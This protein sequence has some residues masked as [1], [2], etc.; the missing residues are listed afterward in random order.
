[1]LF[2][3][4]DLWPNILVTD[5]SYATAGLAAAGSF[6]HAGNKAGMRLAL[7]NVLSIEPGNVVGTR[8]LAL[9]QSQ[10]GTG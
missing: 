7:D 3:S 4:W 2:R 10:T 5:S 8:D 6:Y 1:M 9:L